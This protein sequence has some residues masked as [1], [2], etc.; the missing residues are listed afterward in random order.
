MRGWVF[1]FD[2][3]YF[4]VTDASGHLVIPDVPSGE[5]EL[6][7]VQPDLGHQEQ[8]NVIVKTGQTCIL[9]HVITRPNR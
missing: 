7:I 8:R 3:P 4:G 6:R 5:Y 2:H 1:V 9:D